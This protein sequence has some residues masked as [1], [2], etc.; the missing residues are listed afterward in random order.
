MATKIKRGGVYLDDYGDTFIA[1]ETKTDFDGDV[2]LFNLRVKQTS[3]R[4]PDSLTRVYGE[5]FTFGKA[6][7]DGYD[8]IVF[9]RGKKQYLTAGCRVFTTMAEAKQHWSNGKNGHHYDSVDKLRKKANKRRI[10]AMKKAY[11]NLKEKLA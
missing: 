10:E 5:D 6:A 9:K 2:K 7:A 1:V 3:Y 4:P 11:N 8:F